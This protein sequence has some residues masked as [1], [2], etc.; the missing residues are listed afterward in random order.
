MGKYSRRELAAFGLGFLGRARAAE[1]SYAVEYPDMLVTHVAKLVNRQADR[2][3]QER[4]KLSTPAGIEARNSFVR[5]KAI[6]LMH[7]FPERNDLSPSIVNT[8]ER[9]GYRIEVVLF[10]SRPNFWVPG[11]LYIPASGSGPFPGIISPC[12]HSANGRLSRAYQALYID[13]VKSGF[14]VLAYDPIGQG[15]RLQAFDDRTVVRQHGGWGDIRHLNRRRG[16]AAPAVLVVHGHG[17]R[18]RTPHAH[19]PRI[20]DDSRRPGEEHRLERTAWNACCKRQLRRDR[21]E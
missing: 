7:G 1:P 16:V 5:A 11:S 3:E 6:E 10:Q 19:R 4:N 18:Q 15:E 12:G 21:Q 17:D 14:V 9:D 20:G 2:W 8:V 13:L